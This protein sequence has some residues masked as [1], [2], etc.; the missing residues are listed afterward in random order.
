LPTDVSFT[1][2]L[3]FREGDTAD[4]DRDRSGD[5]DKYKA[6]EAG[7]RWIQPARVLD[8]ERPIAQFV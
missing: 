4:V 1:W 2:H 7:L 5:M 8:A 6:P 3:V